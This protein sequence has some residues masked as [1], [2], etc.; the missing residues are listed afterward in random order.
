MWWANE[1]ENT[2]GPLKP[3]SNYW[4]KTHTLHPC[5]IIKP[6]LSVYWV[7]ACVCAHVCECV[8]GKKGCKSLVHQSPPTNCSCYLK[9]AKDLNLSESPQH[10]T[11]AGIPHRLSSA[12]RRHTTFQPTISGKK[13]KKIHLRSAQHLLECSFWCCQWNHISVLWLCW[14][15]QQK[16]KSQSRGLNLHQTFT[17]PSSDAGESCISLTA[18]KRLPR[19]KRWVHTAYWAW[20]T[21]KRQ[22]N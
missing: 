3:L 18:W 8:C 14:G 1:I 15:K 10:K 9:A 19:R 6:F 12:C 22:P 11:L 7:H 17:F 2:R 21:V 20:V 13:I 5:G 16:I 4:S